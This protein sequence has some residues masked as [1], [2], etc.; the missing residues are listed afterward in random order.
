MQ[1]INESSNFKRT[2]RSN[3]NKCLLVGKARRLEAQKV[4]TIY[5]LKKYKYK[6]FIYFIYFLFMKI[7]MYTINVYK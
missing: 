7:N 2:Q 6:L 1:I 4:N 3:D 5:T